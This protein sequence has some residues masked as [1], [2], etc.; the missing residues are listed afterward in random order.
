MLQKVKY[1]LITLIVVAGALYAS[2]TVPLPV[3]NV[4]VSRSAGIA[5]FSGTE[6]FGE[7]GLPELPVYTCGI[8]LPPDADLSSVTYSIKGLREGSLGKFTVNPAKPPMSINGELWPS[9]RTI[10]DGRDIGVYTQNALFPLNH[11]AEVNNGK[12][13]A[14]KVLA[15]RVNLARYNPVSKELFKVY[16]G[17]LVVDYKKDAGYRRNQSLKVPPSAVKR[18]KKYVVNYT[19]FAE[20][21]A[22]DYTFL[23]ES[24]LVLVTTSAVK[25]GLQ[26]FDAL[27]A[28]KAQRGIEVEVALESEW[29]GSASSLRSYL[30]ENYQ[31]KGWEYL[32]IIGHYQDHVPM[33][34]FPNYAGSG[35]CDSD[36]P[37]AQLDGSDF[38][39]DK[40]CE[41][42]YGRY[43]VYSNNY[44]EVDAI[45]E[46]TIAYE[47][48]GPEDI[49]WRK[50]ALLCGPGYNSGSNM[51]CVPLN[52]VHDDFVETT[53]GWT[54]YRM[55]GD[56]WGSPT[57]DFDENVGSGS[58][59]ISKI[60]AKWAEGP[61]GVV[62]W[63]TH[64][65]P[66][67]AQD[68]ISSSNTTQVGNKYPAF[69]FC[70][71]CSNASPSSSSNLSWSLLKNCAMGAIGGTDL[72]YYGGDYKTSGS[73]NAWAYHFG[74]TMIA[75]SM[76]I[77]EALTAL[78][79]MA[80]NYGWNNR[81]P[82]VLYGDPTIGVT[83]CNRE[84]FISLMTPNGGEEFEQNSVQKIL[85]ADNIQGDV[86]IE[87]LKG[88]SVLE[89]LAEKVPSNGSY[90]W[91]ITDQYELAD[92]YKVRITDIDSSDL[93]VES[94]ESFSIVPEFMITEYPYFQTFDEMDT[95]FTR[96]LSEKWSQLEDDDFDWIVQHG[97]TPS[98]Q[99]ESTGPKQ[100]H[101]SGDGNYVYVEAS[102]PNNPEKMTKMISP[103]FN[104]K[105]VTDPELIFWC[106]MRSDS[107]TMGNLYIDIEVD[108]VLNEGVV[109][110]KDDHGKEWFE[111]KQDLTQYVGERV[112][113]IF[114]GITGSTWCGDMA[115]DDFKVDGATPVTVALKAPMTYG[116]AVYG[117]RLVYRIPENHG[118]GPVAIQLFNVQ[119][120]V[121]RTLV[122]GPVTS[123]YH[124]VTL[125]NKQA[126]KQLAA[127]LYICRMHTG[128]FTK[129]VNVLLKE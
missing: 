118:T 11:V 80:P 49:L 38:K 97:P 124:S 113:F 109:H 29:G 91:K 53:P 78:R 85:W 88:G 81:A 62:D 16:A 8:L 39:S 68:V 56:R 24:K 84:P 67:S 63:A 128:G 117:S 61:F 66:S 96:P 25:S 27:L 115:V 93:K 37:F 92:D 58:G 40:T 108:G 120:K 34:D 70:G 69:V 17:E 129:T 45:I 57:G 41:L 121:V 3:E 51:A 87:L 18:V 7:P 90:E 22:N 12:L 10:I 82:Y 99:Y 32:F 55:Y 114:R 122:N 9:T 48:A 44:S 36:W 104:L 79:E 20:A 30:Q 110:L 75:D 83:T 107:N 59:A 33:M 43:P 42:H 52:G 64:G 46:K 71:S 125:V 23:Q 73:D 127:G 5:V 86:K 1:C 102:N 26:K 95:G 15:V 21:Y 74:R 100:D 76:T 116:L 14:F 94:K 105:G 111:V 112:F 106:H 2:V 19:Q 119:G 28:S 77:G 31:T 4:R 47:S 54:S 101:T 89:V 35:S 13:N 72:T 50:N 6:L 60:V 103:K 98:A 65:S 123:G 126:G